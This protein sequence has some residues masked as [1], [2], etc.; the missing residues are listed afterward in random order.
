MTSQPNSR[1]VVLAAIGMGSNLG[2]REAILLAAWHDLSLRAG[3]NALRLSSPYLSAPLEMDSTNAFVN[4]VALVET[5]LE[6]LALLHILQDLEACHGRRRDPVKTGH[7]DRTLDLD[8]LFWDRLCLKS[9][10]LTLPHPRLHERLFVLAPLEEL[11]PQWQH[12][13]LRGKV[14]ALL[15]Q[16]RTQ[17]T[18]YVE[19][20]SWSRDPGLYHSQRQ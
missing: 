7:Q 16:L 10:E 12:P 17:G 20:S 1:Q 5:T 13:L 14:S 3:I 19:R 2:D 9:S 4:A 8:L 15:A 11:L 18:Q 6:P